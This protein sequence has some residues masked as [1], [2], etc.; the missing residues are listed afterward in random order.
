MDL[1]TKGFWI[2]LPWE[3]NIILS[4]K[5]QNPIPTEVGIGTW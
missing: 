2:P 5:S 1:L 4:L 3:I